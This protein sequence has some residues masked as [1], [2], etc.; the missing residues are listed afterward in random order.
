MSTIFGYVHYTIEKKHHERAMSEL[1]KAGAKTIALEQR[2]KFK[3]KLNPA[4][5]KLIASAKAG[6]VIAVKDLSH[7]ASGLFYLNGAADAIRAKGLALVSLD[8]G[9]DTRKDGEGALKVFHGLQSFVERAIIKNKIDPC[10][11][12]VMCYGNGGGQGGGEGGGGEGGGGG[13]GD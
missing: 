2:D 8:D 12:H 9:I 7:L 6:D 13:G 1:R 5:D 4:F 10:G 11:Y 3:R